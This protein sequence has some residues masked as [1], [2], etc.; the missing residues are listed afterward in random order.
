MTLR[1]R[2]ILIVVG[3]VVVLAG[4]WFAVLTPKRH[5]ASSLSTQI[6]SERDRLARA[7]QAIAQGNHAKQAYDA[8]YATVARLG[9]AVPVDDDVPSLLYQLETAAHGARIDFRSIKL[10]GAG[11]SAT[12]PTPPAATTTASGSAPAAGSTGSAASGSAPASG[13]T[14]SSS[15]TT[16]TAAP[17]TQVAAAGLPP[18]AAV[19]PAGL[20]TMPFTFVFD[21]SFFD[22]ERFLSEVNRFISLKRSEL[23]VQGRLL[24]ID[25]IALSA[26]P[27]GFPS[28]KA[29]MTATAFLLPPGEGL[30]NGASAQ[31]PAGSTPSTGTTAL[32]TGATP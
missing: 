5:D 13:S 4:F 11:A 21:G 20:P 16:A 31:G 9:K 26:G 10:T 2:T 6:V 25:G 3:A 29:T 14:A 22:M 12:T 17:A 15:S 27:S 32:V 18:G 1:D 8:A 19:G 23:R 7:E 30:L 24:T 28:V